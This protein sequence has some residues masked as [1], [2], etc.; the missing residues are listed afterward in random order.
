MKA[1]VYH[2]PGD[3]RYEDAA[4]PKLECANDALVRV[5]RAAICGSDLHLWRG[6]PL[7]E[8][9]FVVGHELVGVVEATGTGVQS[10]RPGDRVFVSCTLGCG[11]CGPCRRGL[12]SACAVVTVGGTRLGVL[13]F[14]AAF[15]GG[16][17]EALRV[18]YAD[19]NV[20]RIP[21]ALDDERAIFLTDALPTADMACEMAEVGPGDTVV[22]LGSG[23]VGALVQRCAQLRGAARVVAVDPDRTRLEQARRRG[24]I[25]VDPER[26]DLP[27]RVA[28]ISGG[29]GADSVIEAVGHPELVATATALAGPGGR[30]AVAGVL[31]AP[32]EFPWAPVFAKSLCLRSGLVSPQRRALQLLALLDSGRLDPAELVTHRLPLARASEAYEI[33]AG[34]REEVLKVLLEP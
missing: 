22:V 9:G 6:P 27:A 15:P 13:G 5:T 24:C 12:F 29:R 7:P 4:D 25:G 19:A 11:T 23:P 20:F 8:Q 26:E 33:F 30:I 18:P 34:H 32:V 17:A 28:E 3:F 1:V 10:V 31:V 16:Q 21:D 14:S 2:G